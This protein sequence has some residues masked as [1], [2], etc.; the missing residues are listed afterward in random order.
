MGTTDPP[1]SIASSSL[2]LPFWDAFPFPD[3]AATRPSS[4]TGC[5]FPFSAQGLFPFGISPERSADGRDDHQGVFKNG[6][7][8]SNLSTALHS[9]YSRIQPTHFFSNNPSPPQ[10]QCSSSASSLP[11]WPSVGSIAATRLKMWSLTGLI[12]FSCRLRFGQSHS[13]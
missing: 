12:L 3:K 13:H 11:S 2:T 6:A 1:D 4:H 7:T 10:L 8:L 9:I 5:R